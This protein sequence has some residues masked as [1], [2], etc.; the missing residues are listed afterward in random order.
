MKYS[1]AKLLKFVETDEIFDEVE[2]KI[3]HRIDNWWQPI[4]IQHSRKGVSEDMI[5]FLTMG[6][7]W[8]KELC[9]EC[10]ELIENPNKSENTPLGL[11]R[12]SGV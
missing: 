10:E 8:E 11:W 5:I 12:M 6:K 9:P 2:E 7:V 1:K 3:N 4:N